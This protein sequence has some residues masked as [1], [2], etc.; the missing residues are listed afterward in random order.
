MIDIDSLTTQEIKLIDHI[1]NLKWGK[2]T[3]IIQ[4]GQAVKIEEVIKYTRL[5]IK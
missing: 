1:R 4:N 3:L 5:T 2:M